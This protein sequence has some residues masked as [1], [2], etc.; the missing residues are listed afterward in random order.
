[1]L[2]K[3]IPAVIAFVL[4][5]VAIGAGSTILGSSPTFDCTT[6]QGFT[7]GS[8]TDTT[9]ALPKTITKDFNR[10]GFD[11]TITHRAISAGETGT[12]SISINQTTTLSGSSYERPISIF[13][14]TISITK[15]GETIY[16]TDGGTTT[17]PGFGTFRNHIQVPVMDQRV[18][19]NGPG[20]YKYRIAIESDDH[21]TQYNPNAVLT[22]TVLVGERTI[23]ETPETYTGWAKT[24]MDSVNQSRTAWI[25]VPII[26]VA[27]AAGAIWMFLRYRF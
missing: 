8:I 23:T 14:G 4:V 20:Q 17:V 5:G 22:F 3:V 1:M 21:A 11:A 9:T 2:E 27:M 15:D 7:A 19:D 24:C 6:V 26:M 18:F 25:L 16:M 13:I 12:V 10:G